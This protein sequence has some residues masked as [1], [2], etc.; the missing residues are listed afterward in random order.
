MMKI[1]KTTL[2]KLANL[3]KLEFSQEESEEMIQELNQV[4]EWVEKSK[5]IDT[6]NVEALSNMSQE[7]NRLREDG[8]GPSLDPHNVL[9]NAPEME[10]GFFKVPK[11]IR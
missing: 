5:G 11:V 1:D 2:D 10:S 4:L 8:A 3:A 7:I 9:Q 6:E